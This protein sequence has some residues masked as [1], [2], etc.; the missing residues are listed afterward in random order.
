VLE[1]ERARQRGGDREA[2]QHEA[3]RIV[4]QALAFEQHH[5][6]ARQ[7]DALEHRLRGDRVGR[8][9][10]RAERE[11]RGPRQRRHDPVHGVA[12]R[13]RR[14]RD[15]ADREQQDAADVALEFLPDGEI[16]AVHQQRRQE[17]QQHELRVE[18]DGRQAGDERDADAAHQ[19]RGGRR[20][21]QS[22]RNAFE[23]DD[24]DERQQNQ[25]ESRDGGHEST[26]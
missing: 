10:D 9:H 21:A 19:Q 20:Q 26:S 4:Q 24:R 23:R 1:A 14:E 8:R 2:E 16:C 18:V 7:R 15:R 13:E 12:D 22:L 5:Q 11:A 6:P 25:L 17:H 3:G